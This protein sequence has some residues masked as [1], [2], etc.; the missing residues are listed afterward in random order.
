M[1]PLFECHQEHR[2]TCLISFKRFNIP[3]FQKKKK[4]K[5][6]DKDSSGDLISIL[7]QED[8]LQMIQEVF[9][10]KN[11]YFQYFPIFSIFFF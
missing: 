10:K 11:Y 2:I 4:K 1:R 9:F 7:N 6:K 3:K 8:L 5:K